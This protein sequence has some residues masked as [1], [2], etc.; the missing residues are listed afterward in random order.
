MCRFPAHAAAALLAVLSAARSARARGPCDQAAP[1]VADGCDEHSGSGRGDLLVV[2]R[3]RPA[4]SR[5]ESSRESGLIGEVRLGNA[6]VGFLAAVEG[7]HDPAA[8]GT[9]VGRLRHSPVTCRLRRLLTTPWRPGS[10]PG[11]TVKL[12]VLYTHPDDP[13]A[14]DRHYLG[15]HMPLTRKIPGP[16]RLTGGTDPGGHRPASGCT[17]SADWRRRT[18]LGARMAPW[19][20]WQVPGLAS[21][22]T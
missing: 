18:A 13:D 19:R 7:G 22:S 14:F 12:V 16:Q 2:G 5:T 6:V 8:V 9:C 11:V 1:S 4:F 3:R 17:G 10:V 20:D 15:T 21:S